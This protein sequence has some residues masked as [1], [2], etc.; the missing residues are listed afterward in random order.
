M[1][2]YGRHISAFVKI[3]A[4]LEWSAVRVHDLTR[5]ARPAFREVPKIATLRLIRD[6]R[7]T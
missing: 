1:Q 5:A 3:M 6:I 4:E 7:L 2:P